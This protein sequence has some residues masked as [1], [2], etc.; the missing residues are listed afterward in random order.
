MK[1][2]NAI[3]ILA[4]LGVILPNAASAQTWFKVATEAS[5]TT[6]ALPAGTTWRFGLT[7]TTNCGWA[8][9]QVASAA[10]ALPVYWPGGK[11]GI[12]PDPCPGKWKELDVLETSATQSI[13]VV[14]AGKSSVV[15]VP[16]L[17]V[18][19]PPPPP[20]PTTT[21]YTFSCTGTVGGTVSVTASGV[22]TLTASTIILTAPCNGVKQ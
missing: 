6:V 7:P 9:T 1:K 13:T 10:I 11:M 5:G 22:A 4:I 17:P 20:P 18:V 8:T 16:A 12:T 21:T 15:V 3:I 14:V 2:I 19:T